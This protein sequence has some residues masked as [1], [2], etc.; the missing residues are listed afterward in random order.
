MAISKVYTAEAYRK[1]LLYIIYNLPTSYS[2][3]V[4]QTTKTY[5]NCGYR[6]MSA[7]L[8]DCWNWHK[9]L[10]WGWEEGYNVGSFLYAPNKNGVGDWNGK[11]ILDKCSDVSTNFKKITEEEMLLTKAQD[12]MGVYI[13]KEMWNGYEFNVAECTPQIMRNGTVIMS[14]GCHLSYVDEQGRRFNHKGGTQVGSWYQHGKLPWID[15][16]NGEV[17][18][19]YTIS[20]KDGKQILSVD[21]KGQFEISTTTIVK[22]L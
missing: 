21:G 4:D 5:Y 13:G 19:T 2:N 8:W 6:G 10:A 15:Y 16:T 11:Q 18:L 20:E 3:K 17:P 1:K 12:H 14:G 22:K 9:T 7:Y